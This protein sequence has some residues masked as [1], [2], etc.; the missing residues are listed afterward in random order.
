MHDAGRLLEI[1]QMPRSM[2]ATD[3]REHQRKY[4][5]LGE[6]FCGKGRAV[7]G[8]WYSLDEAWAL[9]HKIEAII[10]GKER[11]PIDLDANGN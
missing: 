6:F 2:N 7:F 11:S 8:S 10:A 4:D 1:W 9:H 5:A 3:K